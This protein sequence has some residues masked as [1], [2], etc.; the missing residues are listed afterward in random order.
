M[1]N[2]GKES[3]RSQIT[4]PWLSPMRK[5]RTTERFKQ[6]NIRLRPLILFYVS[7]SD[8]FK[9]QSQLHSHTQGTRIRITAMA[10]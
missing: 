3:I 9:D 4:E 1:R 6:E 5:G 8:R 10:T 2:R 7:L